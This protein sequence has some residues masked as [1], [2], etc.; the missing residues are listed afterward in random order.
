MKRKLILAL[1][2]LSM[3]SLVGCST[4]APSS[5]L[6]DSDVE[7]I[8]EKAID[9]NNIE[10]KNTILKEVNDSIETEISSLKSLTAKEQEKL[11]SSIMES[12][13]QTITSV[14]ENAEVVNQPVNNYYT[15]EENITNVTE[16][17]STTIVKPN[18]PQKIEDGTSIKLTNK[19][20]YTYVVDEYTTVVINEATFTVS[21]STFDP[22]TTDH[23]YVLNYTIKAKAYFDMP[24]TSE[25]E[26]VG[27]HECFLRFPAV[28]NPNAKKQY[29]ATIFANSNS[30]D[31]DIS[32]S[33][34]LYSVPETITLIQE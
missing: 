1:S 5:S 32:S 12:V 14:G 27:T 34:L 25:G 15:T 31:I 30:S 23:P 17:H 7:K 4:A 21:N 6:T 11:K 3:T 10:L 9:E 24:P 28:F 2:V 33:M 16:E 26:D 29:L 19:L 22:Y 8:V 13:N 20:P 18:E